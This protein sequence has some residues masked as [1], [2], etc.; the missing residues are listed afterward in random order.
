[1]GSPTVSRAPASTHHLELLRPPE[2]EAS[3]DASS[4][5]RPRLDPMTRARLAPLIGRSRPFLDVLDRIARVAPTDATVLIEGESGTGKELVAKALHEL[6]SRREAAFVPVNCGAIPE[7]LIESEL[8]GHER[9]SF[10][11]A[12]RT[13][14]GTIERAGGGTLFLDEISEMPLHMQVKLLRVLESREVQRVGASQ[15]IPADVR[16]L[17]ATNR[18]PTRAIREGRLREDL[19]FRIAVFPIVLPP[20]RERRGDVELLAFH[21]L[22]RL[23]ERHG[24]A[25]RWAAGAVAELERREWRG[26]VR[27]LKNA[28]DRAFILADDVVRLDPREA[29]GHASGGGEAVALRAGIS[30]AEAERALILL[31][32]EQTGGNKSD[33][34]RMLGVSLKTLYNRLNVYEAERSSAAVATSN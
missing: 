15:A 21:F 14:P 10:T 29:G 20:L 18:D 1:M 28:V 2:E 25:K 12:D 5:R 23:N 7:G 32:L 31:T 4:R 26:N 6:S 8:F 3:Y 17:A 9:G 34:A 11:G 19:Y 22:H 27:E 33:A 24:T 16:V 30:I 13:Q